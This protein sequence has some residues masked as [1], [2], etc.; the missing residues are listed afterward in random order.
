KTGA[1]TLILS[2]TNTYSGPTAA[3]AGIL[4]FNS[5]G[6]IGGTGASVTVA[7]GGVAAAGY[8]IDQA[9]IGR[10]NPSSAGVVAATVDSSNSLNFSAAGANLGSVSFGAVGAATYSGTLTPNGSTYRLGGGGG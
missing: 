6:S 8:A 2:G 10:I 3:T 5:A 7:S 1:G 9:F 4:Q